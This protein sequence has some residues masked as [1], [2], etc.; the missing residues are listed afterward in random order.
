MAVMNSPNLNPV[1]P[2]RN[3][4]PACTVTVVIKA[5]NEERNIE[6]SIQSALRGV[7]RLGGE[8]VLADSFSTDQ[9]IALAMAYP[10]RIVQLIDPHERSCGIGPQIG[11]QHSLGEFVYILDGDMQ[12]VEG[13]LEQAVSILR[14]RSELAGVGGGLVEANTQ[15]LEYVMREARAARQAEAVIVDRLDC[16]GLYR[17]EAIE[18]AGYFSDRNLHSYEEYDLATRLRAA[19]WKLLRIPEGSVTHFGHDVPAYE[20]LARRFKSGYIRG[21]G[22]LI[23]AAAGQSRFMDVL[24]GLKELRL[25]FT[26]LLWWAVL[27]SVA[28]WPLSAPVRLGIAA[29]VLLLP[30]GV[31]AWRKKSLDQARYAVISWCFHTA[32]MLIGLVRRQRPPHERIATRVLREPAQHAAGHALFGRQ[33]Q[34]RG[35]SL[36][37]ET[38]RAR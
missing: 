30:F 33:Q 1:A 23:R 11:Y 36:A 7:A 16:G 15:S 18:S 12:L 38:F 14:T 10:I 2:A 32:G 5:L 34:S 22:E 4:Q 29:L 8:V 21:P 17:R 35:E 24:R 6:A 28:F 19:G 37:H 31:M 27:A 20:L 9:T 3:D 13:F 25:Y 26:V